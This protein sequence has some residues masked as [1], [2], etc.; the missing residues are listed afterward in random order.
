VPKQKT[1]QP[2]GTIAS[3]RRHKAKKETPCELCVEGMREYSR[4]K[5]AEYRSEN[6][7]W[8]RRI[9]RDSVR[10]RTL[11]GKIPTSKE[12][13]ETYAKR[14]DL[15]E[16]ARKRSAEWKE[17]N[18]RKAKRSNHFNYIHNKEKYANHDRA[19]R[20]RKY[21]VNHHAYNLSQVVERYGLECWVCHTDIDLSLPRTGHKTMGLHLDHLIPLIKGGHDKL[22]NIR[23]THGVCNLRKG[24]SLLRVNLLAK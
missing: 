13:A 7:E 3:Y 20:A 11:E 18:P 22:G 4:K 14:P 17:K 15:Q 6:I 19:R 16:K 2:C 10:K 21:G 8:F 12:R 9:N 23:P 5:K 1:L 24:D